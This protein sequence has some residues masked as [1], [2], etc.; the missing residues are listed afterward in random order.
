MATPEILKTAA[1]PAKTEPADTEPAN[2]STPISLL[3][4]LASLS[5]CILV[6]VVAIMTWALHWHLKMLDTIALDALAHKQEPISS[7]LMYVGIANFAVLKTCAL[8]FAFVLIF[9]GSVYVLWPDRSPLKLKADGFHFRTTLETASPGLLMITLGV[10]LTAFIV[11]YKA[12]LSMS[13]R[14]P[15]TVK[16]DQS[17]DPNS[18]RD[19]L[20]DTDK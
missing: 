18:T 2:T 9:L 16:A 19:D 12:N 14:Y 8:C 3:W 13:G 17:I 15:T 11:A 1:T 7:S 6:S 4:V 5:I 20:K 10:A